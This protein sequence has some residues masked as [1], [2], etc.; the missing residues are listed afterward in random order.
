MARRVVIEGGIL[1]MEDGALRADLVLDGERIA[2]I[3][4]DASAL[5]ADERIDATGKFVVPGAL[6]VHTHFKEPSDTPL[7]GFY[8]G[9]LGAIAGGVTSVVEMPQATPPS[10][11]GAHIREKRRVGEAESIVD[12]ALWG[13][14]INQDLDKISEMVDEGIVAVKSFMAGS[15]PGFPRATD[16][17]LL[18]V[19]RLLADQSIPYGLHAENDDLLQAGIAR[20]QAQGRKDVLAHAES[21]PPIVEVE[22]IRRALFFAEETGGWAYIVHCSTTGGVQAV[23]EAR[24]RG[25]RVSLETCPQYLA[26]DEEDLRRLGPFGR[27][28][29]AIRKQDEVE[30]VWRG[31]ADGTVDV[32]ASDHCGY[33]VESKEAGF[34]D[35]WRAPLGLSGIQTMCPTV[36][37][38]MLHRRNL[39]L[40]AF[41]RLT[42]ANPARLFSLYPRKGT[43]QVGADADVAIY[44]PDQVWTVRGSEM[45]HRNKWTPFEGRQVRGRVVRTIRRGRTVYRFDGEPHVLGERGTGRFL[46]RAYG[47]EA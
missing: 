24:E 36:L 43:L 22:A 46:P 30:G 42:A 34:D 16:A 31:V 21:R 18:D 13:A 3:T 47:R 1:G 10:S 41:V 33:T 12:F 26:L 2:A 8:T 28:A 29:P 45:L 44:D 20:M 27:C 4:L 14:A 35:I 19:F 37:D 9:S 25:V 17:T 38:E 39:D 11:E 7:E 6:D 32:I 23:R 5:D 15:S 40:G